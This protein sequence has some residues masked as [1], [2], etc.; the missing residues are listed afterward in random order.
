MKEIESKEAINSLELWLRNLIDKKLSIAYGADYFYAKNQN[1]QY[2]I[3][4]ELRKNIE[5]RIK[6]QEERYPRKVDALLLDEEIEIVCHPVLYKEFF[7][8]ALEFSYPDGKEEVRTFLGQLIPIRNKLFHSNPISQREH[9]KVI[10]Y[11]HDVIDSIKDHYRNTNMEKEFNVPSILSITDSL[12]NVVHE[13]QFIKLRKQRPVCTNKQLIRNTLYVGEQLEIIVNIDE[14]FPEDT[15]ETKW[16]YKN[17]GSVFTIKEQKGKRF[18]IRLE[19]HHIREQFQI[20][21]IVKSNKSWHR[22][23]EHDDMVVLNYKILPIP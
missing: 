19:E 9:E 16:L 2:V 8:S 7:K 15:Y 4:S 17:E 18:F 22:F 20:E 10:C 3:K 14:T 13:S 21:C 5:N 12:G 1:D 23:T 11:C 6:G